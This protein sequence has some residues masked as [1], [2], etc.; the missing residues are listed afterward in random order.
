MGHKFIYPSL[1]SH[2]LLVYHM[3]GI[4]NIPS[5]NLNH[6]CTHHVVI[7]FIIIMLAL[8]YFNLSHATLILYNHAFI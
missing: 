8:C 5:K 6:M 4:K 3:F 2:L 7:N 1:L